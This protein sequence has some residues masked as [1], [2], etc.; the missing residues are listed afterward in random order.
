M[1]VQRQGQAALA[2]QMILWDR[3]IRN[4][5]TLAKQAVAWQVKVEHLG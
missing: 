5:I 2:T 1:K 4:N 3:F